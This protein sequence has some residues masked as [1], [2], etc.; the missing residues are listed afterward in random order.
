[1]N[2]DLIHTSYIH[3]VIFRSSIGEEKIHCTYFYV[4]QNNCSCILNR[5]V[6]E[7]IEKL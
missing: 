1:M 2:F 6:N 3:S 5:V 4:H 7:R